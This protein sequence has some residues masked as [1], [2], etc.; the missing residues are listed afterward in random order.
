MPRQRNPYLPTMERLEVGR[1]YKLSCR[2]LA[3]GVYFGAGSFVGIRTK[4]GQRFLDTEFHWDY[5]PHCGTVSMA[6]ATD[7]VLPA[8]IE[9]R[10]RWDTECETCGKAVRWSGPPAPAPWVHEE[11]GREDGHEVSPISRQNDALFDF[12]EQIEK[13]A[14]R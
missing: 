12:M 7:R 3:F 9:R 11:T 1:V 5:D 6:T 2:N 10:E 14:S 4:F 13:A 8:S